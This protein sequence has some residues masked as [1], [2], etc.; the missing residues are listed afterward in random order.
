MTL[1]SESKTPSFIESLRKLVQVFEKEKIDYMLIGGMAL[2]A[3][4]EIRATQDI[5][6]AVAITNIETLKCLIHELEQKTFEK[7]AKPMLEAACI[8]VLDRENLVDVEIWLKPDGIIFDKELLTRRRHRQILD[9][10]IWIIGP[11]D[12]IVNKL[13]RSDRSARDESDVVSV[14]IAQR[15]KLD[16]K[17]LE[18][19]AKKFSILSLLQSLENKVKKIAK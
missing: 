9:M 19:R 12:F 16:K 5:D 17:Y 11:E 4:G 6:V 13:S 10:D 18:K 15:E 14:L 1:P 2:P 7:T 8:Y 3:Y